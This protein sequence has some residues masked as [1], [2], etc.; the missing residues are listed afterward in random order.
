MKSYSDEMKNPKSKKMMDDAS[1]SK[2]LKANPISETELSDIS[3]SNAAKGLRNY[4]RMYK[5]GL[6]MKPEK[7]DNAINKAQERTGNTG[8]I[9]RKLGESTGHDGLII[10][11]NSDVEYVVWQP[12]NVMVIN[13]EKL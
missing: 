3:E 8:S 4:G 9:I 10:N 11:R 1:L 6:G 5:Q 12:Y 13:V 2:T 7:A